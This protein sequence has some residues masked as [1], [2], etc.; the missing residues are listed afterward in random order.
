MVLKDYFSFI[1]QNND[2]ICYEVGCCSKTQRKIEVS[3]EG[4]ERERERGK[5]RERERERGRGREGEGERERLKKVKEG[6]K[7]SGMCFYYFY[8]I[9][10]S[11][12]HQLAKMSVNSASW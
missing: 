3:G 8:R 11:S 6:P 5:E 12:C 1:L 4:E 10:R 2:A 9:K 7:R